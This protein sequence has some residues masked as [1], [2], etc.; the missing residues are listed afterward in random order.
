MLQEL[1]K[2]LGYNFR[3]SE[4]LI[5]ALTHKS[6]NEGRK[7]K[8][9]TD[10]ERLEFLGDSIINI[11]ITEYLFKKFTEL[12]EGDLSKL[13]A[14]LISTSFLFDISFA[15]GLQ[16]FIQLGKGEEKNHGR[17]NRR[18]IASLFEA[19]SG[20]LYLDAGFKKSSSIIIKFFLG[21]LKN[22]F[23]K[24][25]KINDYKSELQEIVQSRGEEIP[26]YKLINE[27]G[28]PPNKIFTSAVFFGKEKIGTG[29]GQNKR[30][31]EQNAAFDA[32]KKKEDFIDFERLSEVFFLKNE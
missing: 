19:I 28:T 15:A 16:K 12:N 23:E 30:Q 7:K 10:N 17:E 26:E 32:L 31:S 24:I 22:H 9:S 5:E 21:F 20:A 2:I 13:K 8:N 6:F 4:L 14:H 25:T 3:D 29:T 11:I 27:S 18:I 1:E